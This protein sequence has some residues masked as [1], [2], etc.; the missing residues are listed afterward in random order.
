MGFDPTA[1]PLVREAFAP[2]R[3]PITAHSLNAP[4]ECVLDDTP[5]L[6]TELP[7]LLGRAFAPPSGWRD[8]LSQD[9]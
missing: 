4:T 2:S 6:E 1:V 9:R 5:C 3:W 7:L 8:R